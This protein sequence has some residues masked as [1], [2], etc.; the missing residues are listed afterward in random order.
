MTAVA[1]LA[2]AIGLPVAVVAVIT[3]ASERHRRGVDRC[4]CTDHRS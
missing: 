1:L 3:A 2:T 4:T